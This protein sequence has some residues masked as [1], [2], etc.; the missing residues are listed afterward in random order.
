MNALGS[1]YN[2]TKSV[3]TSSDKLLY[4]INYN[5]EIISFFVT[6]PFGQDVTQLNLKLLLIINNRHNFRHNLQINNMYRFR[7]KINTDYGLF[8]GLI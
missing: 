7:T 3:L 8:D 6:Y 5:L 2:L 1:G 4:T